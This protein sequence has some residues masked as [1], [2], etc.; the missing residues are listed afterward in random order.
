M[1]IAFYTNFDLVLGEGLCIFL[2]DFFPY[3]I[4]SEALRTLLGL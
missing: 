4:P 2:K 1:Q 3:G